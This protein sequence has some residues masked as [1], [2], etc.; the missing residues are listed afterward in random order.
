MSGGEELECLKMKKI[1]H[2]KP[3]PTTGEE[4][5]CQTH[6]PAIVGT[7]QA[8]SETPVKAEQRQAV[9]GGG[10][11]A[12]VSTATAESLTGTALELDT[13]AM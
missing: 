5:G 13:Y 10:K 4:K 7:S 8:L 2:R 9:V 1:H 12:L 11:R 6:L 3:L